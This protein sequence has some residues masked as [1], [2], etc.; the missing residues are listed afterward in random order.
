M[1]IQEIQKMPALIH[2]AEML[3][4]GIIDFKEVA[5]IKAGPHSLICLIICYTMQ[6]ILFIQKT[7]IIT[8]NHLAQEIKIILFRIYEL[9]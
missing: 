4:Q 8:M 7:I 5:V 1:I 9:T 3:L 2:S 6:H